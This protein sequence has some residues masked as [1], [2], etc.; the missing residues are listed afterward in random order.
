MAEPSLAFAPADRSAP[1]IVSCFDRSLQF[2]PIR[3]T[4]RLAQAGLEPS[5]GGISDGYG[6]ALPVTI[7]GLYMAEVI[8]RKGPWRSLD[9]VEHAPLEWV[10][11]YSSRRLLDL[12]G[13]ITL[14]L[15]ELSTLPPNRAIAE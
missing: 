13:N 2:V 6:N 9:Q 15:A 5:I 14:V 3:N 11:R 7:N 8:W 10:D 4:D 12:I 1:F